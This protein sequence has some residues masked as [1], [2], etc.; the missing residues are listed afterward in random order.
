MNKINLILKDVDAVPSHL[1]HQNIQFMSED[2]DQQTLILENNHLSYL[3]PA[4]IFF[5]FD[6]KLKYHAS[7]K[8]KLKKE[9]LAKSLGLSHHL[10]TIVIDGSLGTGK[11]ALL[12]LSF[13]ATLWGYERNPIVYLLLKD[14]YFRS[15]D[16]PFKELLSERFTITFGEAEDFYSQ[17]N[18]HDSSDKS[19]FYF[20]PMFQKM[21]NKSK[22]KKE[23]E[24]FKFLVGSDDDYENVLEWA[25]SQ[26]FNR[27]V[28]KRSIHDGFYKRPTV[29]FEGKSVRYDTYIL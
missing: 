18:L 24:I 7:R 19:V 4:P 22:S 3:S 21:R 26:K 9:L 25:C 29:S 5:D 16:G 27:V 11:D 8:Y 2:R 15:L 23:M 1:C 12:M 6:S 28:L 14:A 20:D 17:K 13:G 10:K